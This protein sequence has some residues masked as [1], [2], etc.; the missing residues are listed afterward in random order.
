[1]A[2]KIR[3]NHQYLR[4]KEIY[5]GIGNADTSREEFLTNIH[6]DTL[7]SLAMHENLLMYNSVATNTHPLLLRQE[8]IKKMVQPLQKPDDRET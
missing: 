3:E 7:A 1:M 2:D 4:Q 6:R 8:L 5:A